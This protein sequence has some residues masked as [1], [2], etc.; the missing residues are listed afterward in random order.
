M[1][2]VSRISGVF[3]E[4]SKAFADIAERPRWIVPLV[5]LIAAGLAYMFAFSQHV[6]WERFMR[7]T[8]ENSPRTAQLSAEQ[9][10]R[11]ISAQA[12]IA[13]VFGY[14]AV[15]AGT[16]VYMLVS[17]GVLLLIFNS[18]YSAE[19]RFK[20]VFAVMCYAGLTGLVFT[21]LAIAVMFLKNPDDFNLR[22][23]LVFNPGAFMDPNGP[24]K[25]L[26]ALASSLDL[27]T[28]WT[29]L[30]VA[31]GL[32]AAGR[33]LTYGRALTGVLLPWAAWVLL[34]SASAGLFG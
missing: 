7:Q 21:M 13:P 2:E 30:L 17:A 15:I 8:I 33:K 25:F 28:L 19:L 23:P 4:P 34:K 12:R 16:P 6:G 31:A 5:L 29:I 20:Q 11:V 9:R 32:S 1:S 27:F 22:N 10:E 24:A 26:Y 3:L 18:L 14:A